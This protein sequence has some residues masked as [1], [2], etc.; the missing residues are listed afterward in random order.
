MDTILGAVSELPWSF[1]L[2]EATIGT[3]FLCGKTRH[4]FG[5]FRDESLPPTRIF[6]ALV[7]ENVYDG[8]AW[9][10]LSASNGLVCTWA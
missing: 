4:R 6:A 8:Q 10:V 9:Q 7:N 1:G 5:S 2:S 3:S